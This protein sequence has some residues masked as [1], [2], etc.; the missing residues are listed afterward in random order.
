[1]VIPWY[2]IAAATASSS[3]SGASTG[4]RNAP[5][6]S[7]VAK[8]VETIQN[9]ASQGLTG[10]SIATP[11]WAG[12]VALANASNQS[13]GLPYVGFV[14]PIL[15]GLASTDVYPYFFNDVSSGPPN[16]TSCQGSGVCVQNSYPP[17][18]GYDL[19]TGLGSPGGY[20]LGY[21]AGATAWTWN[22]VSTSGIPTAVTSIA[23]TPVGNTYAAWAIDSSDN[24]FKLSGSTWTLTNGAAVQVVVSPTTGYPWV[25][26]SAGGVFYSSNGGSSWPQLTAGA[27]AGGMRWIG[28]GPNNSWGPTVWQSAT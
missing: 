16:T 20:L 12:Y 11:I 9:G 13:A 10:T 5:V 2:Q 17:T 4:W 22:V 28:V 14:N 26:N 19:V 23:G 24:I 7:A 8:D 21:L 18:T 3:V 1:M 15:Y 6:V 27:P 25:V